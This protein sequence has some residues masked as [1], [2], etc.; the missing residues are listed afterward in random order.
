MLVATTVP[1]VIPGTSIFK[2][3]F[4]TATF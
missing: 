4:C 3:L 1:V 2:C